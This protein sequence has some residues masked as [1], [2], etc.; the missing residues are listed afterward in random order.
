MYSKLPA[1]RCSIPMLNASHLLIDNWE[2]HNLFKGLTGHILLNGGEVFK[3]CAGE[4]VVA[5]LFSADAIS[6][7]F[8]LDCPLIYYFANPLL[9]FFSP[10]NRINS[11][12]Y[13]DQ[14]CLSL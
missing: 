1:L 13:I 4:I 9:Y 7:V 12:L 5:N 2:V 14:V 10:A 6:L 11:I 3:M 8:R